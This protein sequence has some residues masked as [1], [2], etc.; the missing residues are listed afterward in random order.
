LISHPRIKAK[1]HVEP[2]AGDGIFLLA[3]NENH[4]LEGDSL[5]AIVPLLDGRRSWDDILGAVQGRLE[6]GQAIQAIDV[7]LANGHVEQADP[8]IPPEM[9]VFWAELG[10]DAASARALVSQ[11]NIHLATIGN[12]PRAMF[13]SAISMFGFPQQYDRA[14]A[15]TIVATDDYQLPEIADVNRRA[16]SYG[17]PWVL[18]KPGG[19]VPMVGP[20]F[21]PWRT[22]CWSCLESR[23][24]HNREV[25]TY[26][27]RKTGRTR[28]FPTTRAQL[29]LA[30][31]QAI[32]MTLLQVARWL[33]T[34]GN[35]TLEGRITALDIVTGEQTHHTVTRR[36]Q[37]PDC[38]NPA[39]GHVA[40]REIRFTAQTLTDRGENGYRAE[41]PE[42]TFQRYSPHI[43]H[44]TGVVKQVVPAR[45]SGAGPLKSYIAGHNFALKNDGLYFIKDGLRAA[46]SGKGKTDAQART[47]A[48]CEALERYSGL[49]RGEEEVRYASFQD[50]G[51]EAVDPTTVTMFSER[52]YAERDA[53]L[54]RGE[55]FQVVPLAFDP[56][57]RIAWSPIWSHTRQCRRWLPTSQL[58][59]GFSDADNKFFFWGDSNGNAAGSSLEDATLQGFLELVERDAVALWWYNRLSRPH[60]DLDTLE[61]PFI[62]AMRKFYAEHRR[63]F[64][65]LDLTA[66]LGIPAI[67]AVNRRHTGPTED[68]VL[69]F[70][71]HLDAR[72]G[73]MR[74]LTE[75]NQFMPALLSYQADGTTIYGFNDPASV[76]W[77]KN[78]RLAEER[79]LQPLEGPPRRLGDLPHAPTG[80]VLEH[81]H[82]CFNGVE[83][84]GMEVLLLDQ[85][86]PDIGLPVVK[87][88]VPGMR[89]FWARFGPGRL[90]DVPVEMG[91][92]A[93][94]L[95][96]DQLNPRPMFV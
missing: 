71:A 4:V 36:P 92:L 22:P 72:V 38:G 61:D 86:R 3:E 60:V 30:Q 82:V 90:Y 21:V 62:D 24:K 88:I 29:P 20:F 42:A 9:Q 87:V 54:A 7:L 2:V 47:S 57:A 25:E 15:L 44:L 95:T 96:E 68:L 81:L 39:I 46:S 74:A 49:Y 1:Y 52:Q 41:T 43:S 63:D 33:A 10:R 51:D 14:A 23:L 35:P 26:I 28:P 19:L 18:V 5:A 31:M 8:S 56:S 70:G 66:D 11:C 13:E 93:R 75:M 59:Y 16:L 6:R 27:R 89:H 67:A 76:N 69:G 45:W 58:Y 79:Y 85:T 55:R 50:L 32:S 83:A 12:V 48:L 91:W 78:A 77:W 73:I 80:N 84:K 64:W 40:G 65:V 17:T 37:C 53:W 34:G 94:P